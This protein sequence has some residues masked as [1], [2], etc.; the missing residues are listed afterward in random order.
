MIDVVLNYWALCRRAIPSASFENVEP[1]SLI[2]RPLG[3]ETISP[4]VGSHPVSLE[5][6]LL[7]K[8]AIGFWA[9]ICTTE[10]GPIFQCLFEMKRGFLPAKRLYMLLHYLGILLQACSFTL[11]TTAES[12]KHHTPPR[13]KR[14]LL[15]FPNPLVCPERLTPCSLHIHKRECKLPPKIYV[16]SRCFNSPR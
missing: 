10:R 11:S 16:M 5:K 4:V 2:A 14:I 3:I 6:L 8:V 7:C 9:A 13:L 15:C 1:P 12:A